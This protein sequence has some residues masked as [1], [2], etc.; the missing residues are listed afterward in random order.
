MYNVGMKRLG[1]FTLLPFLALLA[2]CP[3]DPADHKTTLVIWSAPRGVEER[4]FLKL[5]ARFEREH[6]A[7][8]VHNLGGITEDKLVR[9][10]VAGTPPDLA[11]LYNMTMVGPL[12]ANRAVQPLDERFN[13]SGFR[14]EDFLPGAIAQGRYEGRIHAMPVTRDSRGLYWNRAV[15]KAASLDPDRPPRTMDELYDYAVKLT[16]GKKGGSLTRLGFLPVT[17]SA[18][19][20]C[21]MGGRLYDEQTGR[22]TIDCPEN[23]AALAWRVKLVDAMGGRDR[24]AG[25]RSGFGPG[26]SGQNPLATGQVAMMIEG[27]WFAMYLERYAPNADYGI[28]EIPYPAG[29]PDLRNMAWQDGDFMFIP[30]G[31]KNPDAA[32]EFIRW[33]HQPAQQEEYAGGMSNLPTLRSLLHSPKL[34]KGSRSRETLGYILAHIS[35]GSK[36]VRFFPS[37]PVT[38]LYRD[39]LDHAVQAAEL[40]QKTPEQA[41]RDAQV[42]VQREL[43]K[44]VR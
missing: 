39:A 3:R 14:E 1:P 42:R 23:V 6:P 31:A 5:I 40:H 32:W 37:L 22:V 15:F 9:A 25:F 27:E 12:A 17:D 38:K 11:Y 35:G 13:R 33:L 10:M 44:Y 30:T 20:L 41:L 24:V 43:D 21:A 2:G 29:R 26:D 18:I 8:R 28:G 19:W 36:N 4:A 16:K 7:I 34:T